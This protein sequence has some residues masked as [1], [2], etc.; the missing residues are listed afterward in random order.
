MDTL[1]HSYLYLRRAIGVIGLALPVVL[2]VGNLLADG[3][4]RNSISGYY[5]SDVRDILVGAMCAV[6][7]FL[8]SYRGYGRVDDMA[9]NI[10]AVA[11]VGIA[12]FPTLPPNPTGGD[13]VVAALH[14]AFAAVFF[15]TL[16]FFSLVLFRKS[17]DPTPDR[18]KRQRN[19]VYL[20]CGIAILA[21]LAL[22]AVLG[23]FLDPQTAHLRPALWLE[24]GAI[25]AFGVSWLTKGEAILGDLRPG[26]DR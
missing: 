12:L 9:G 6:G 14:I 4:M 16:A 10:A 13:R 25:L 18:R 2:V 11:A 1:V 5:Y 24:A 7:V 20:V 8:L 23:F 22:M 3:G 19:A 21:C 17:D 15:L 26:R